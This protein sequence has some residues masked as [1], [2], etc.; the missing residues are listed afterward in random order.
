MLGPEPQDDLAVLARERAGHRFQERQTMGREG[1]ARSVS[2]YA[3]E[4]IAG[5]PMN[6]AT[7]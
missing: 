6:D 3:Q 7:K 2:V 1:D 4:V 5:L